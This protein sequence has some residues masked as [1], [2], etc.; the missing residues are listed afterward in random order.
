V[1]NYPKLLIV[2]NDDVLREL[3]AR[4]FSIQGYEVTALGHPREALEIAP[5]ES[6]DAALL[7]GRLPQYDGIELMKKLKDKQP[8][9]PIIILSAHADREFRDRC[10]ENGA[11]A[12]LRKPSGL[13]ELESAVAEAC[14][15]RG[16][17]FAS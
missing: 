17:T 2:D 8:D 16:T 13:V 14:R 3:L 10:T 7:D 9:L 6:F 15:I 1:S 5:V 4:N 11:F 12:Y